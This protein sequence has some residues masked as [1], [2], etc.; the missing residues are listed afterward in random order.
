M[1]DRNA[2][3]YLIL[4]EQVLGN[5]SLVFLDEAVGGIGDGLGRAVVAL[6]L[7]RFDARVKLV[8]PQYVINIGSTET[9]DTLGI[10]AY[11][12][13][14]VMLA[15]QL[16]HDEMLR[17]VS[18]L[19]LVNKD[20]AEKLLIQ[21]KYIRMISQHQV[22]VEQQVIKVHRPGDAAALPIGPVDV[23]NLGAHGIAVGIN[24]VLVA[25]IVIGRDQG[26]LGIAD[27]GLYQ[28]GFIYLIIQSHVLDDEL[29]EG[30]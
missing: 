8:Q 3:A 23:H 1:D 6:Q 28:R 21:L 4:A 24:Q 14:A 19:I 5:L 29:D 25:G 2:V 20:I 17:E 13:Q 12:T 10:I 22:G 26:V 27:D 11:H 30:A 18:V 7:E 16:M 15:A 9:I